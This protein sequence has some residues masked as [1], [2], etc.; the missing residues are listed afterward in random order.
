MYQIRGLF[1]VANY[2]KVIL[3][4][5]TTTTT[6]TTITTLLRQRCVQNGKGEEWSDLAKVRTSLAFCASRLLLRPCFQNK[7]YPKNEKVPQTSHW[8]L[9]P[10]TVTFMFVSSYAGPKNTDAFFR[11]IKIN[12]VLIFLFGFTLI[13]LQRNIKWLFHFVIDIFGFRRHL[14]LLSLE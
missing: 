3:A 11:W 6:T 5:T 7:R 14:H 2:P 10:R 13:T 1:F 4:T 9:R 12:W 8:A